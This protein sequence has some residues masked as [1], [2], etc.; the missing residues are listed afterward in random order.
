MRREAVGWRRLAALAALLP[1]APLAVLKAQRSRAIRM[2]VRAA[3][4]GLPAD[5][6]NRRT[7]AFGADLAREPGRVIRDGVAAVGAHSNS[8]DR[9]V[10]VTAS[11]ENLA[12][13]FLDALGLS[14]VELVAS[15]VRGR[16]AVV[17]NR[18][19]EKVRQLGACGIT[20]PWQVAYSD[21][22]T[23]LPM[24]AGAR[25]AVLVNARPRDLTRARAALPGRIS[26][27]RWR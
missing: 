12:R 20:P 10:V 23:D 18:G 7:R 5:E 19:A 6:F 1:A 9:V 14:T 26:E 3:L 13:A 16:S 2:V 11:E 24:L 25:N 4:L 15:R 27:V 21:S 17:H 8:G 22:L